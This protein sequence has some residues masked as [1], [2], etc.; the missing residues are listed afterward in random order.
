MS[1]KNSILLYMSLGFFLASLP[2]YNFSAVAG[3][4][5]SEFHLTGSQI[6]IIL[7]AFQVGYVVVV[8]FTGWLSDRIGPKKVVAV[9]TLLAGVFS[10]MFAL[11][12]NG[13]HS[14]LIFRVLSG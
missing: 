8:L 13:F 7:S 9:A 14:I 5:S 12:A 4:I 3:F 1:K 11:L 6:G 10:T 2:W